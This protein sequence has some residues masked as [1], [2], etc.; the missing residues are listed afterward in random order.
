M[1]NLVHCART[2]CMYIL[3]LLDLIGSNLFIFTLNL[4]FLRIDCQ[5]KICNAFFQNTIIFVYS[6]NYFSY[7]LYPLQYNL[8]IL[9]CYDILVCIAWSKFFVVHTWTLLCDQPGKTKK[10]PRHL[11]LSHGNNSRHN[12]WRNFWK[13]IWH[14]LEH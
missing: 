6:W 10:F 7:I 2:P 3:L 1:D 8:L 13:N 11:S 14:N 12:V 5:I 4:S 9:F